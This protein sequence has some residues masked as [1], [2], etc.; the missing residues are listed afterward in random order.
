M[1]KI[2][3]IF[4]KYYINFVIFLN[5]DNFMVFFFFKDDGESVALLENLN[6]NR[7]NNNEE[8]SDEKNVDVGGL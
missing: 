4:H 8:N 2:L 3:L 7:N 5:F 6:L 1:D